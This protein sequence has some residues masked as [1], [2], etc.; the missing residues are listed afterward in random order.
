MQA[1]E[2]AQTGQLWLYALLVFGI[3]VLPGMDMAFVMA[4]A[5]SAGR[6]AGLWATAG[7]VLG[8]VVH[9][10]MG[11]LGLS[12]LLQLHPAA[13][14]MLLIAGSLY[15]AWIGL[16]L[17][18][19]GG[20]ALQ[21][22][23]VARAANAR[24]AFVRGTLTCLMNPKAYVFMLAVFPQFVRPE[25][26]SLFVQCLVVVAITAVAQASVYG[27]VA[28]SADAARRWLGGRG[29]AQALAPRAVGGLLLVAAAWAVW[30]GWRR[31]G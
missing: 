3:V 4:N 22:L 23:P 31:G 8:G 2:L 15:M 5:L 26:G 10:V 30:E 27:A 24:Q 12:V 25:Y 29:A 11:A 17:W 20:G 13:F 7:L 9:V 6:H 16:A 18:R 14:N 21:D 1:L 19:S 28:W